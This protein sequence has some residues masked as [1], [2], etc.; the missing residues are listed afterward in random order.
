MI[1]DRIDDLYYVRWRK[2]DEWSHGIVEEDAEY[3]SEKRTLKEWH[4]LLGHLNLNDLRE[5]VRNGTI[6]GLNVNDIGEDF[7]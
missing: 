2:S 7:D 3:D 5:A 4:T 1:A 6:Q